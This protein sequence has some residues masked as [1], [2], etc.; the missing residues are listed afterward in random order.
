MPIDI[1]TIDATMLLHYNPISEED[2]ILV[3]KILLLLNLDL[4][5]VSNMMATQVEFEFKKQ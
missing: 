1:N 5:I 4:I 2:S 3:L